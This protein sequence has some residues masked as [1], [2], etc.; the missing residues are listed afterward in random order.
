MSLTCAKVVIR[1]LHR[2][3]GQHSTQQ[4]HFGTV[5]DGLC[6]VLDPSPID[7]RAIGAS[8]IIDHRTSVDETDFC[9]VFGNIAAVDGYLH[10]ARPSDDKV[11]FPEC[12][13]PAR[14]GCP[15][16]IPPATRVRFAAALFHSLQAHVILMLSADSV[17]RSAELFRAEQWI[18][19]ATEFRS[20]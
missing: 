9:M 6:S 10:I 11:A 8:R 13:T 20:Y 12:G 4:Q 17:A 5:C 19:F 14:E 16:G 3:F 15:D 2:T 7:K 18:A 1:Q